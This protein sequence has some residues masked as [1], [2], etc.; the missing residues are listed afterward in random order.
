MYR[1][2]QSGAP[3]AMYR[4]FSNEATVA[5]VIRQRVTRPRSALQ[6]TAILCRE[7]YAASAFTTDAASFVRSLSV[8]FSSDNVSSR[9]F[10]ASLWPRVAAH[11]FKV[12]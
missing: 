2:F 3:E 4:S 6:R 8:F 7:R 9:S 5:L 1:N 11:V 10:T 12:P